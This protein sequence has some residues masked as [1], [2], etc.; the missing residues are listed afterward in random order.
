[1][2]QKLEENRRRTIYKIPVTIRSFQTSH[3]I[4][5]QNVLIHSIYYMESKYYT[6]I[7]AEKTEN[8][9]IL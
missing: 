2:I 7:T 9:Q 8:I 6:I 5:F 3:N 1:M 4:Y